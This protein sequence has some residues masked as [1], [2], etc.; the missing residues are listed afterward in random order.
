MN[1]PSEPSQDVSLPLP[2]RLFLA[3]LALAGLSLSAFLVYEAMS[4]SALPGCGPGSGCDE[5]LSSAWS[6]VLGIPVAALAVLLYAT[7]L[8]AVLS[9]NTRLPSRFQRLLWMILITTSVITIAA[10][11]YFLALQIGLIGVLCKYCA[12]THGV[13]MILAI[14][15]LL[16]APVGRSGGEAAVTIRIPLAVAISAVGM[17]AVVSLMVV[18][19]VFPTPTMMVLSSTQSDGT[20]V[21]TQPE[22]VDASLEI[23][24]GPG[25]T[26][27]ISVLGRKVELEPH[28]HPT[29]GSPDAPVLF[30]ELF[31]YTCPHCRR[32]HGL[33]KQARERYGDQFAVIRLVS[34]LDG[35]CNSKIEKTHRR[36]QD[37]CEL[38]ELAMAVWRAKP[39]KFDA[40]E[41]YLFYNEEPPS[42]HAAR[43]VA[44]KLVGEQAI[45]EALED[46]WIKDQIQRNLKMHRL[47]EVS[48]VPLFVY[49][50]STILGKP[51]TEQELYDVLEKATPL[52]PIPQSTP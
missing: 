44:A 42:Q 29:Y 49:G 18:Q 31:D 17:T 14:T 52:R 8:A 16:F 19:M 13:G 35:D 9:L 50:S 20:T 41:D 24:T 7:I 37:A 12:A 40:F 46:Q 23:D 51:S 43:R 25:P 11:V 15:L 4:S 28:Q 34:P 32:M 2:L 26:R 27:R 5:V 21:N 3:V 30:L 39:E 33:I 36:H 1:E 22:N 48:S 10:A 38:A 6:K 47:T 45:A